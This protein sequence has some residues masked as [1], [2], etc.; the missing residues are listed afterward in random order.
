MMTA[1][2]LEREKLFCIFAGHV[3]RSAINEIDRPHDK[4]DVRYRLYVFIS[5]RLPEII[6]PSIPYGTD[7]GKHPFV[8]L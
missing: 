6:T 8:R 2:F 4:K 3:R 1:F 5:K 7:E